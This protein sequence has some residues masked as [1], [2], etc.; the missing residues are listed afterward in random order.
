MADAGVHTYDCAPAVR[1]SDQDTV[2]GSV[3]FHTPL[4][5]AVV[6]ISAPSMVVVTKVPAAAKPQT[7]AFC[8]AL[9]QAATSWV[10]QDV[11]Y[12]LCSRQGRRRAGGEVTHRCRTMFEPSVLDRKDLVTG[13]LS[14]AVACP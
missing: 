7:T 6:I 8:G 12:V 13:P 11:G 14:W 4:A 3:C 10:G 9:Q 5:S 1:A 2:A